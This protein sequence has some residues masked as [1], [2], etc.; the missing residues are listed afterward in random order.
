MSSDDKTVVR[1]SISEGDEPPPAPAEGV[2]VLYWFESWVAS[3][4]DAIAVETGSR[5]WTYRELSALAAQIQGQVES[6]ITPGD[7]VAVCARRSA[8]I[9]ASAVAI[10]RCRGV[11]LALGHPGIDRVAMVTAEAGV[12]CII[13]DG[14]VTLPEGWTTESLTIVGADVD[15]PLIAV[16]TA[17]RRE[18]ILPEPAFY[19]VLTSGSTG[20]PRVALIGADALGNLVRWYQATCRLRPSA[21]SSLLA[22]VAFDAHVMEVWG[23]LCTGATLSITPDSVRLS[24]ADLV[25][26]LCDRH[27]EVCFLPTPLGELLID[28][29][30]PDDF[31]VRHLLI[32]GDR[33]RAWPRPHL[34]TTVHNVYG[35]AE[36]TILTTTHVVT[37][38]DDPRAPIP[39][40]RPLSGVR[41]TVTDPDGTVVA[42]GQTGELRIWGAGVGL[43]YVNPAHTAERF[44]LGDD[45]SY[46][47]GD[48]VRMRD[49][50]VLEFLG[51]FDDQVKVS[52]VRI[53][54]AEVEAALE[55]SSSVRHAVVVPVRTATG[56]LRLAAFVR[57]A[58]GQV[59]HADEVLARVRGLVAPQAVP[60]SLHVLEEFPLNRNNKVDRAQ[61]AELARR[62]MSEGPTGVAT[63]DASDTEIALLEAWRDLLPVT[64]IDRT[65][66][67]LAAG[68]NSLSAA[69]LLVVIDQRLGVRLRAG[70]LLR[71]PDLRTLAALID[72]R[73]SNRVADPL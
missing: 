26:W 28:R 36:A 40:G 4:P 71:Q 16:N 18:Q 24:P 14:T 66:N 23:A 67:F 34:R 22:E 49:D 25:Q 48:R 11:Y 17:L 65:T 64:T 54:P 47:T 7:I 45:R 5:R 12:G 61:L 35:P 10:A 20:I 1:A 37:P 50:G 72:Q 42:R 63:A 9:V 6:V 15:A 33:M 60:H 30:W 43:G 46:R 53:E 70:E 13:G 57:P 21:R 69:R 58:D 3:Q 68:G 2:G 38:P 27:V 29:V 62:E 41:V 32:G 51:R 59:I 52:G 44:Q 55:R 39:I 19:A 8:F 73:V 31:P 56:D